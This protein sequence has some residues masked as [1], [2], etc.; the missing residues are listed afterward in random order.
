MNSYDELPV[1]DNHPSP[2]GSE[3]L[4]R[5]LKLIALGLAIVIIA[6]TA[7]AFIRGFRDR[8]PAG[9]ARE[10]V[11]GGPAF[12]SGIDEVRTHTADTAKAAVIVRLSLPYN[13]GD[14]RFSEELIKKSTELHDAALAFFST[15]TVADLHPTKEGNLKRALKDVLNRHLIMGKIS[16]V[17]FT[18]FAVIP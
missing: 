9:T 17:L 3:T 1:R 13:S 16:E 15:K 18:E 14:P 5:V 12:F 11:A 6:G 8:S 7:F 2:D 10:T 4:V